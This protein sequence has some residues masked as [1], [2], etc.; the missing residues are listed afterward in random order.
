[1]LPFGTRDASAIAAVALVVAVLFEPEACCR[2]VEHAEQFQVV[3]LACALRQ[4]D[5]WRR[6]I[7]KPNVPQESEVVMSLYEGPGD[8]FSR[9]AGRCDL[10]PLPP[11]SSFS[12]VRT[13]SE[14]SAVF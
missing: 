2:G 10:V 9:E 4:F 6:T 11:G 5:H 13:A 14:C 1:P 7:V 12:S 3:L 8:R